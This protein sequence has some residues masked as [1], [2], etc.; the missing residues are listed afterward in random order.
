MKITLLV[1]HQEPTIEIHA[2][3]ESSWTR[4]SPR[5]WEGEVAEAKHNVGDKPGEATWAEVEID[6]PDEEILRLI[7]PI[8]PIRQ[9]GSAR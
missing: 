2:A 8:T 4:E 9:K 5:W 3:A 6:V 1:R 7:Y